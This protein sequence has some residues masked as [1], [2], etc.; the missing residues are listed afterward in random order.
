MADD[1]RSS[2]LSDSQVAA[3]FAR[4][5]TKFDNLSNQVSEVIQDFKEV[6]RDHEKRIRKLEQNSATKGDNIRAHERIDEL[7]TS[8]WK[9]VVYLAAGGTLSGGG[10]ALYNV[11]G[12]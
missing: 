9:I 8:M 10:I 7:K 2:G 6:N 12:G 5:E 11:L 1:K 4:M 3:F